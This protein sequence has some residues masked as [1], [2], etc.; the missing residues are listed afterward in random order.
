M[1]QP[2]IQGGPRN[3]YT[4]ITFKICVA[5]KNVICYIQKLHGLKGYTM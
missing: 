2:N 3:V 4:V 1:H 5:R